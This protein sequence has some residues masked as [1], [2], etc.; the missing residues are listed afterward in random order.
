M[1][2]LIT[3]T[4][5]KALIQ[6]I[7]KK[8]GQ[9]D[10][11][12]ATDKSKLADLET[13]F[14]TKAVQ[15]INDELGRDILEVKAD[16]EDTKRL[17]GDLKTTMFGSKEPYK[18]AKDSDID[19][20]SSHL[21]SLRSEIQGA[22]AQT[23]TIVNEYMKML[24]GTKNEGGEEVPNDPY[25]VAK[26]SELETLKGKV[27]TFFAGATFDSEG[28]NVIDT[29]KEIVDYLNTNPSGTTVVADINVFKTILKKLTDEENLFDEHGAPNTEKV[30][31]VMST[32]K[33][34]DISLRDYAKKSDLDHYL[35][36]IDL[37]ELRL[38]D[39]IY[40]INKHLFDDKRVVTASGDDVNINLN[41]TDPQ[42]PPADQL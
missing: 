25:I 27:D 12:V 42:L 5:F 2:K 15:A 10:T 26:A 37:Q 40:Q 30:N 31:G 19:T 34:I 28:N 7:G 35:R 16:A 9:I 20:I 22:T 38:D 1:A 11:Q 17:F 33:I 23:G 18:V 6:A 41:A 32:R 36:K 4:S 21:Q 24:L 29:L 3:E 13:N 14:G 39:A 8:L